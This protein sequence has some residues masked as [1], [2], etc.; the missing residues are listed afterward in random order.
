MITFKQKEINSEQYPGRLKEEEDRY[1]LIVS[2]YDTFLNVIVN[3]QTREKIGLNR[4]LLSMVVRSY[5]DDI[6]KFK[7]YSGSKHADQYKKAAYT[8]KWLVKFKPI[9][10]RPFPEDNINHYGEITNELLTINS[11]FAIYTGISLFLDERIFP[12]MSPTFWNDLIYMTLYREISGK[13][14]AFSFYLLEK[15]VAGYY[16]KIDNQQNE[17]EFK[18]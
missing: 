1:E 5:F 16:W 2:T 18:I 3:P 9:Q 10:I 12:L 6:Y 17:D 13:Q 11:Q 8:T 15:I 7:D 4:A 14:L